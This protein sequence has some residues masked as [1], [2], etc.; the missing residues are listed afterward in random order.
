MNLY[1]FTISGILHKLSTMALSLSLKMM[2]DGNERKH[3]FR[4]N[5]NINLNKVYIILI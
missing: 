2:R 1:N 5:L 4:R 3:F